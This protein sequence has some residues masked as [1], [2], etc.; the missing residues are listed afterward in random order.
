MN[1]EFVV[2]GLLLPPLLRKLLLEG[3]WKHPGH[4]IIAEVIPSLRNEIDRVI[5]LQS[6]DQM[7]FESTGLLADYP[8]MLEFIHQVR[9][10]KYSTPVELPWLDVEKAILIAVNLQI[11]ADVAIALDYR[12]SEDDPRVVASDWN[13]KGH[14][15]REVTPTFSEFV[16]RIGL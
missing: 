4:D 10:S 3:K 12:T 13:S 14:F 16:K 6:V 8:D 11:G 9:G 5:F 7:R 2:N 15:W 1:D